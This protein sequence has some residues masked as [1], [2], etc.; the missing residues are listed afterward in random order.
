MHYVIQTKYYLSILKETT[1]RKQSYNFDRISIYSNVG[2]KQ[3]MKNTV[4]HSIKLS[5]L[6][7][8]KNKIN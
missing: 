3:I 1:V 6:K 7:Y 5:S 2:F 8:R 4:K